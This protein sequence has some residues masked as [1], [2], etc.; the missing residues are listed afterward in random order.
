MSLLKI[1]LLLVTV[2]PRTQE[3]GEGMTDIKFTFKFKSD[4]SLEWRLSWDAPW[5]CQQFHYNV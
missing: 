5:I 2:F 4:V 1:S 3:I